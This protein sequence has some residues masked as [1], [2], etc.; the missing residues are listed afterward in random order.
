M[1]KK[2]KNV[3]VIVADSLR[4]DTVYDAGIKMPYVQN[5]SVQF[6][7]A[8][9]GGCWTLPATASLF[10]GL[11]PHEH[12]ATSQTRAIHKDIPTLAERMKEAGYNTYQITANV[13]TTHIFGLDRGFDEVRRI[14]KIVP[15]K[16][17]FLAQLFAVMSKPR[18]RKKMFKGDW[19]ARKM[20]E[21][22][23]A[24]KT[25]LQNTY[26]DIFVQARQIL[27]ENESKDKGSFLFLN[28]METHFPY[29]IAPTL[30][31]DSFWFWNKIMEFRDMFRFSNQ[32]F[33]TKGKQDLTE[34]R[35]KTIFSRQKRS[36]EL[37]APQVD[38]FCKEMHENTDNLVVFL[39]D[40]GE[41]FG[42]EGWNYHFS[43]VTD[44]GNKVPMFWM[45]LDENPKTIDSPVSTRHVHNSLLRAIGQEPHGP[46]VV[47]QPDRSIPIMQSFWYNNRGRTMEQYKYNQMSFFYGNSRYLL[48]NGTWYEAPFKGSYERPD[49][50]PTPGNANPIEE[51]IIDQ[52]HKDY[53]R[54]VSNDFNLFASGI[55]FEARDLH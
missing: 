8:R 44:A 47:H 27:K 32:M 49:F 39:A 40:H 16:F 7:E 9:S 5:N 30:K 34:K 20:S 22:L 52:E 13:A 29:H 23:E 53:L 42:D 36:W 10:T 18:L 41:N 17:K 15:P 11:M 48:K 2:P 50:Q 4:F 43:N 12:G 24:T 21:D 31:M 6:T 38:A 14:W 26:P 37:L 28:L 45:G 46:S 54:K 19:L 51:L 3:I 33:L 25:W 1:P 55:S 35:L